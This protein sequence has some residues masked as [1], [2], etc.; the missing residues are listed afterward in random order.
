MPLFACP[1][2]G[3]ARLRQLRGGAA[4][5]LLTLAL[6][7]CASTGL[8][9]GERDFHGVSAETTASVPVKVSVVDQVDPSDWETVRRAVA[10]V[11][12]ANE[13]TRIEW[14]N[15][16]TGS[17]GIVATLDMPVEHG[18]TLCRPFATTV[19]DVHG[20]RRYRG[21][22]CQR[23]DGRWQLFGVVADDAQFS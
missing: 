4:A 12:E 16:D 17:T 13:T 21:E 5:F 10:G 2:T 19:S 3:P 8:P 14:S 7:G 20:V 9:L 18:G 23:T 11:S 1:Y 22:A 6:G 15:P